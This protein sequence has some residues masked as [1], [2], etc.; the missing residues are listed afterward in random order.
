VQAGPVLLRVAVR[1][2][3][4]REQHAAGLFDLIFIRKKLQR[5]YGFWNFLAYGNL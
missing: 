1:A 4:C 2:T 5:P 3:L